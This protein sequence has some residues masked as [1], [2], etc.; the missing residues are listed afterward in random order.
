M[1]I[2]RLTLITLVLLAGAMMYFGRD[3]GLPDNRLG[4]EPTAAAPRAA[5][6]QSDTTAA[7]PQPAPPQPEPAPA[8]AVPE[9]APEPAAEPLAA[10][11]SP[12]ETALDAALSEALATPDT[13]DEP[14]PAAAEAAPAATATADTAAAAPAAD[15]VN[16]APAAANPVLY[17]TGSRVNVRSGPATVYA[18][19]DSLARG[20]PVDD[21]GDAGEGWRM[22]RLPSGATGYM[23]GDYLSPTAP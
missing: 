2:I 1:G 5:A 14:T 17:V 20:T 3:D 16:P 22:I 11:P 9:P 10:A 18:A 15:A 8:A 21:L 7:V 19:I 4:R 13:P 6:T 12:T 23:S